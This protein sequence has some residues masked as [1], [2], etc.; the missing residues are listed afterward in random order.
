MERIA[1]GQPPLIL[2]DGSATMDFISTED[3][4]RANVLAAKSS[5]TDE[6]FNVASGTETSLRELAMLLMKVMGAGDLGLEFGPERKVNKVSRRLADVSHAREV[7]GFEAE[8]SLEEGL[9]RLVAWWSE[10]RDGGR[11]EP[12]VPTLA[13]AS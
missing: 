12:A 7:L 13:E 10:H 2:G 3:I 1:N 8:I 11:F 5:A 6:V 9:E 4:A